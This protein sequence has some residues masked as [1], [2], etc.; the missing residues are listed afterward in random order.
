MAGIFVS[1]RRSDAGGHVGRLVAG[2]C[3]RFPPS[4]VFQ[5]LESILAGTE[6][7]PTI[8]GAIASSRVMLVVIGSDWQGA[9]HGHI[10]LHDDDDPVRHEIAWA[11][12]YGLEV[13]PV[14][15]GDGK[16]PEAT[17]LPPNIRALAKFQ[18]HAQSPRHWELDLDELAKL[19][20]RRTGLAFS[21]ASVA[22][23][24][25]PPRSSRGGWL[26]ASLFVLA[27]AA[28]LI[29]MLMS[30]REMACRKRQT[31]RF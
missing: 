9:A 16:M 7:V 13:I 8:N 20:A 31:A 21:R 11:F 2:L 26:A 10:R 6:V 5:D 15:V 23:V 30:R 17:Q 18:P 1:Y 14:L 25:V 28:F 27:G 19:I 12:H 3:A 24:V 29:P 4:S 22:P